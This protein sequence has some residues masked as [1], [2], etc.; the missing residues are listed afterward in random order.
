MSRKVATALSTVLVAALPLVLVGNAVWLLL[1]TWFVEIQY[2]LPGFPVD[3]EGVQDPQRTEL[4][5]TGVRA[6]Q[7]GSEGVALLEEA[8][9]ADGAPAFEEREIRHM[10]DVRGVV[11][12]LLV[13][14]AVALAC[15]V[16]A[17]FALRRLGEPGSVNR[18]LLRGALLTVVA[19]ALLG[20]LLAIAFETF[21]DAFHGVFF[22]D[23]TWQFKEH[24][25]LRQL[26]PDAFWGIAAA[27]VAAVV[28]LQAIAVVA[29]LRYLQRRKRPAPPRQQILHQPDTPR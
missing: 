16:A 9:L 5:K 19:M 4:A 22:A 1:N 15:A 26:Y 21:F 8:R 24:F 14:W 10:A 20:I 11:A 29:G 27:T 28:L 7:P 17:G 23:G 2:A 25:T 12:G 13:A 6:I 18:A 3:P